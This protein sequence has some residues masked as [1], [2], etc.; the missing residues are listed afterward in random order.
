MQK[1]GFVQNE[2]DSPDSAYTYIIA[3]AGRTGYKEP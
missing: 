2:A 1:A 3:K